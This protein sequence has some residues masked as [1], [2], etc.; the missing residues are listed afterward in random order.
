MKKVLVIHY[1]QSGQLTEIIQSITRPLRENE[2]IQI[3][4]EN[5]Q[6]AQPYPFPWP[7][8]EFFDVFPESVLME[9]PKMKPFS[10]N[11][12][13]PYDLVVLAYQVWYLSP[14]LP[15]TAFLKSP[16]AAVMKNVPVITIVNCKDRWLMA[17]EKVKECI[18]QAGGKLIDNVVLV[19]R[20][21][22]ITALVTTLRWLW[23]GKKEGFWKI[24]PPAGVDKKD[25]Y[26]A[27]RFG[28]AIAAALEAKKIETG[29]PLL[30]GLG[31][32]RVDPKIIL[33][34]KIGYSNFLFW[35][36]IVKAIGNQGDLRRLPFLVL[37]ILYIGCLVLISIPFSFILKIFVNLFRKEAQKKQLEYFEGPSGSS[38]GKL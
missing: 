2:N 33:Q 25:I 7:F 13:T 4:W 8:F 19:H 14:S 10:F 3:I 30:R 24:F 26:A 9:A 28:Q 5:L 22:E 36:K 20:G 31:A 21:N 6:P 1:S 11:P 16:E 35:A 37:F 15:V 23:T 17:Q 29:Q 27:A 38:T 12:Q 34:E 18:K 32:A